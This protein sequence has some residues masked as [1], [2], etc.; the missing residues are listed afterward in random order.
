MTSTR[1]RRWRLFVD[2]ATVVW[3]VLFVLMLLPGEQFEGPGVRTVSL[4]LLAVF[5]ADLGVTYYRVANGLPVFSA[6]T[7]WMF[8]SSFPTSAF[9]G[10][11]EWREFFA[12]CASCGRVVWLAWA[13]S[14]S[15][16][17]ATRER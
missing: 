8:C 17:W 3:L 15:W 1:P 6:P 2:I 4:V 14:R 10:F 13:V 5:V 7:G 9:F 11:C 16:D 12:R